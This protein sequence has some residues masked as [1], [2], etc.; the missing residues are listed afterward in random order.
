MKSKEKIIIASNKYKPEHYLPIGTEVKLFM[1][2]RCGYH[3]LCQAV[4]GKRKGLTQ[5]VNVRDL[6]RVKR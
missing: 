4:D 6:K 2:N 5:A 3:Y 1:F